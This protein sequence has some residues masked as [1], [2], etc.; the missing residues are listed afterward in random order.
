MKGSPD[1]LKYRIGAG[2]DIVVPDAEKAEALGFQIG[3]ATG[4]VSGFGVL[5]AVEFDDEMAFKTD[6]VRNEIT[7]GQLAAEFEIREPPVA[8]EYPALGFRF[9]RLVTHGFGKATQPGQLCATPFGSGMTG[10]R[11]LTRPSGTLSLKGR[12]LAGGWD[13]LSDCR[14]HD[15]TLAP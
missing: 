8:E 14:L 15:V 3:I 1:S 7:D 6:E 9:G 12:G 10:R 13:G 11:P 2:E 5:A 4:V